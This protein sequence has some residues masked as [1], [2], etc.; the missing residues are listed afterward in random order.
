MSTT[1]STISSING[2]SLSSLLSSGALASVG[3]STNSSNTSLASTLAVS[4]LASGMDWQT[5]VQELA[6]AERA[7]ETQWKTEQTALTAQSSAFTTIAGALAT[8]QTDL[9][10]L[11]D[12]TLY[13]SASAQSSASG[14]ATASAASGATTG[15]YTFN[16]SQL[17]T[18]AQINGQSN[19]NQTLVPDG[20]P[21]DVTIGTAG[22]ST[23]V[24]AG[25]IMVDG[26][27]VTPSLEIPLRPGAKTVVLRVSATEALVSP[28]AFSTV[29]ASLPLG[30]WKIPG[31]EYYSGQMTYEKSVAIPASLLSE[32][33]LLDCGDVG[34]VAEAWVN[35]QQAGSR[36]WAPYVFDITDQVHA[37][38]NQ[39]KVLVANTE[40]N[41]RA[42]GRSHSILDAIDLDGFH[43]P[44]RLVPYVSREIRLRRKV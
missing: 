1:T 20:N 18:A 27:Q 36:A 7:P 15:S 6:T 9:Q 32:R 28:F 25:T 31:Q 5:T 26:A 38:A 23:P 12:P 22:F 41:G 37:G 24:T 14:I 3:S 29:S 42:V 13:Q 21:A 40:S 44:A 17:A 34:V 30:S 43:G 8:L 16:I 10:T 11:Q 2:T 39:I 35:G 4:G 19:I 33:L